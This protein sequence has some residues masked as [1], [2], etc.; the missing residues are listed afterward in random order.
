MR[1]REFIAGLGIAA[2]MPLAARAQQPPVQVVGYLTGGESSRPSAAFRKGLSEMGF[3][4]G[5]NVA[6]EYRSVECL[7]FGRKPCFSESWGP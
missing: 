6:I 7:G 2:A 5:K 1:R 4:E 3:V